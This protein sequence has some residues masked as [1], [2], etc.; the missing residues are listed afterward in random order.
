ME[1]G[2]DGTPLQWGPC[3]FAP[4]NGY[5][6]G[7]GATDRIRFGAR[8]RR[9][10]TKFEDPAA[11]DALAADRR[12]AFGG[13][14]GERER[15]RRCATRYQE[16]TRRRR[17][18]A[19]ARARH[20]AGGPPRSRS[21][22]SAG[23]GKPADAEHRHFSHRP[24]NSAPSARS[25]L[26]SWRR[27][28]G[29]RSSS[30]CA[31][32]A[33]HNWV[34]RAG[35]RRCGLG[36]TT[37]RSRTRR[38]GHTMKEFLSPALL[39]LHPP[40]ASSGRRSLPHLRQATRWRTAK[41]S[42][43][44]TRTRASPPPSPRCSCRATPLPPAAPSTSSPRC[45]RAG[46]SGEVRGLRA[47]GALSVDLSWAAGRQRAFASRRSRRPTATLF[48]RARRRSTCAAPRLSAPTT[49]HSSRRAR[50]LP[51]A[52]F[53]GRVQAP[54]PAPRGSCASAAGDTREYT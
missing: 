4:E 20:G 21:G 48:R 3:C 23:A 43:N 31:T 50:A 7:G 17:A 54:P 24:C 14:G 53:R 44:S 10:L 37:A 40:L 39:G 47:R 32:A 13:G 27:R 38:C 46:S 6:D 36:S 12:F 52:V 16:R 35:G 42:T 5:M 45:R 30:V 25:P 1:T 9:G 28:R 26:R 18:R 11:A 8:R 15:P 41:A 33:S 29:G 22:V 34:E 19:A 49:P 51:A 2:D